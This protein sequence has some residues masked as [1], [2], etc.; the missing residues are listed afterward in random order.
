[1]KNTVKLFILTAGLAGTLAACKGGVSGE[2]Q[3]S[4][5]RDR[6][7]MDSISALESQRGV[8]AADSNSAEKAKQDSLNA[9]S[10]KH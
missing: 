6:N 2:G 9:D 10:A 3:D 7:R 8:M 1:M 5:M 4:T